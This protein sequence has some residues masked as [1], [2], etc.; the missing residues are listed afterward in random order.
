MSQTVR[1]QFQGAEFADCLNFQ[2]ALRGWFQWNAAG[3]S[4]RTTREGMNTL[5]SDL[6][7][8]CNELKKVKK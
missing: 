7:V 2:T 5:S 8:W 4:V 1:R 3:S 6:K